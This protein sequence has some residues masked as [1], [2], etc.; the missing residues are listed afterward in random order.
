MLIVGGTSALI[1]VAIFFSWRL[2]VTCRSFL[3][4]RQMRK[5]TREK[6][7]ERIAAD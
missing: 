2:F 5:V 7:A 4:R 3:R 1:V 6:A